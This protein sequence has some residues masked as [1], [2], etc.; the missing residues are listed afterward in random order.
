[1]F[2]RAVVAVICAALAAT[3]GLGGTSAVALAPTSLQYVALGDSFS[4]GSGILPMDASSPQCLRSTMNYPSYIAAAVGADVVDVTCGSAQTQHFFVEQHPGTAPQLDAL[5]PTTDLVTMTIGGNDSGLF[6]GL[7]V[8]CATEAATTLGIGNPCQEK[9]GT[10]FKKTIRRTT[11]PALVKAL[12]AVRQKAP[13]ADVAI[14]GYPWILPATGSCYP[15]MPIAS[16][17][18]AYVRGIQATLN[19]AV[20]RAAASTGAIYVDM[21]KASQGRD[22]CQALDVRWIEPVLTG[23]NPVIVHPNAAGEAAIGEQAL[24]Q[25]NLQ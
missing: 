23:T 22:A 20:E 17:D 16:G 9:H 12:T 18:V 14:V 19:R 2:A 3:Q 4:A 10:S 25:L 15:Q 21:S 6:R 1:M 13:I 24:E 8:S 11:Y 5:R 7:V